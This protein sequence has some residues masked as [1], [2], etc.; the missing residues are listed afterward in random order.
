MRLDV[1]VRSKNRGENL[2]FDPLGSK[3]LL[4]ANKNQN[5]RGSCLPDPVGNVYAI[6][7]SYRLTIY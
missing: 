7:L 3:K 5:C 1:K 6:A 4:K 2:Y